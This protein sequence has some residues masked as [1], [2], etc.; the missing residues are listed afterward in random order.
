MIQFDKAWEK[1]K[2]TG[3]Q[4]KKAEYTKIP[5]YG[6]FITFNLKKNENGTI[7]V[8][9][10]DYKIESPEVSCTDFELLSEATRELYNE[11]GDFVLQTK[12]FDVKIS[13]EATGML[14]IEKLKEVRLF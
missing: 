12:L 11:I 8:T 9:A 3:V 10:G 13:C 1:D 14:I 5:F 6:P 4:K 2:V 7:E